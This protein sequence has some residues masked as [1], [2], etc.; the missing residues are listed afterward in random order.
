MHGLGN[1]FV[2]IDAISQNINLTIEQ[3]CFIADRHF[4]IGCDQL[5]LVEHSDSA[6]VDF[7]YRIFNA[8]GGEVEQCGNGARCFARFVQ[9]KKLTSKNTIIVETCSGVITLRLNERGMVT[10]DMGQP[11]FDVK[12]LPFLAALDDSQQ[13]NRYNLTIITKTGS[14]TLEFSAVSMGNPHITLKSDDLDHYPVQE[15]GQILESHPSFPQRVNVGF[16]QILNQ[17][18]IRLRVYERGSGETLACGTGACAAVANAISRNWLV[19]P[20]EVVLPAGSLH[21]QWQ[22][23]QSLMMTGPASFVYEGQIIL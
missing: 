9:E 18:Q 14:E 6:D 11:A 16:M 21:I 1:D 13:D 7:K 23:G 8:D 17:H 2:V 5:L 3:I 10:V 19:S 12:Q 20:V 4:G 22:Q 15:I